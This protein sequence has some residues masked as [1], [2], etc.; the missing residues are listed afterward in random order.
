MA[1]TQASQ[2][3]L[4]TTLPAPNVQP[5]QL[6]SGTVSLYKDNSWSSPKVDIHTWDYLFNERHQVPNPMVDQGTWLAFNL[7]PGTVMTLLDHIT[8]LRPGENIADLKDTG[9]SI[10][11]IGVGHTVAVDLVEYKM[12]DSIASFF[13]RTVDLTL[14]A[15]ELF[16]DLDFTHIRQ[17]IFLADFQPGVV[18]DLSRWYMNDQMTSIRWR[19]MID[20]QTAAI[21]EHPDGAG[22]SYRNITGIIANKEISDLRTVGFD[23]KLSS[24]RWDAVV[25][26]K[27][28]IAPFF[29]TTA[30]T[31]TSSALVSTLE[32]T[33][34]SSS[35]QVEILG[36][37]NEVAQTITVSTEDQFV[38]SISS[39]LT[40][41][42]SEKVGV[43]GAGEIEATQT[44][45]VSVGFQYSN[46]TTRTTSTTNTVE[47][48]ISQQV[49]APPFTTWKAT[50]LV[51]IGQLPPTM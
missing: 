33:N 4:F 42:T 12:N 38:S 3:A 26:V 41:S 48:N 8:P 27:E 28:I 31:K 9:F 47:L 30:S 43:P 25:P 35:P 24:F 29:V 13:W 45:S 2:A 39:S 5:P 16:N 10:D 15:I 44:W 37:R 36:L 32:G 34:N 40:L 46:T 6:P 51:F 1:P 23:N 19:P 21:F 50:L 11:L 17:I 20:R 14:G 7:P 49:V 18:H 22:V